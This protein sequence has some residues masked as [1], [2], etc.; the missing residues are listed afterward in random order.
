LS[1]SPH[2]SQRFNIE[3]LEIKVACQKI[4]GTALGCDVEYFRRGSRMEPGFILNQYVF[5]DRLGEGG[6]AEVWKGRHSRLDYEVAIKFL[7]PQFAHDRDLQERFLNE[8]KRQANLDHPNIVRALDFV[9]QDG[10]NFLVMKYVE[11]GGLDRR[12]EQVGGP[13]PFEEAFDISSQILS[14]LGYAHRQNVVHRDVKTS[15][16]LLGQERHCYLTDF[17]IALAVGQQRITRTGTVMGTD[18]YMS[19]EQIRSPHTVDRRTDI[20]AFGVVL[21]EMLTGVLPFDYDNDFLLKQAHVEQEPPKP[22]KLNPLISKAIESVVLRALAKS[23]DDRWD[24]CEAMAQALEMA[25]TGARPTFR[26]TRPHGVPTPVPP[27]PVPRPLASEQPR[28][29]SS[30]GPLRAEP[31]WFA[32][33]R[34]AVLGVAAAVMFAGLAGF[35]VSRILRPRPHPDRDPVKVR[36]PIVAEPKRSPDVPVYYPPPDPGQTIADSTTGHGG[37]SETHPPPETGEGTNVSRKRRD[38][39]VSTKAEFVPPKRN[40]PP[41]PTEIEWEPRKRAKSSAYERPP[42]KADYVAPLPI[43]PSQDASAKSAVS[44]RSATL[45]PQKVDL[46]PLAS[47]ALPGAN[48]TPVPNTTLPPPDTRALPQREPPVRSSPVVIPPTP[49]TSEAPV[50]PSGTLLWSVQLKRNVT[51]SLI[52][53]RPSS[54]QVHGDP[55]PGVPVSITISPPNA[56]GVV[57]A[58]SPANKWTTV[59][60]RGLVN[61]NVV[62]SIQWKRL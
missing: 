25:R 61:A 57:E 7:K 11:G 55:L 59:T 62:V 58:P 6:M 10:R 29:S 41:A 21:F 24:D 17:G 1:Y 43:P 48:T 56:A 28:I 3:R 15:N 47:T 4:S 42:E 16:I 35:G 36:P 54:G 27:A 53:M 38:T 52:D 26:R 40:E 37:A 22:S 46:P 49:P 19:P 5:I 30:A 13:L 9:S 44:G 23:P 2:Y 20:Y 32:R 45:D 14:A 8:G 31:S 12:I 51:E 33:N 50:R 60:L 39:Q 34:V 18:Y